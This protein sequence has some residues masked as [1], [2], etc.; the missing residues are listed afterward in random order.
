MDASRLREI[1]DTIGWSPRTLASFLAIHETTPRKWA[2]GKSQI[3]DAVAEWL[4][5]VA[6]GPKDWRRRD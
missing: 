2:M 1:L 6:A 4:E 3:P 5:L